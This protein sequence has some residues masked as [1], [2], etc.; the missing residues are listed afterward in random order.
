MSARLADGYVSADGHVVEPANLWTTRMDRRF[1]D[2]A[3]HIETR[4][5]VDFYVIDGLDPVAVGLDGA[6]LESK[7][8]GKVESPVARH[9]DT[10]PGAWDP[11]ERLKDQALDNL[12][13]EVI[14]PGQWSLMFY[15]IADAEYQRAAVRVYNDWL[16]EFCAYAPHR[17]LGAAILPMQGPLEWAAE[18]AERAA[19]IGLKAVMIPAA[20]P[21][22]PYI[23]PD[24][25][26]L[27]ARLE[28]IGLPVVAHSGTA[29]DIGASTH[30]KARRIGPGMAFMDEKAFQ[31]MNA[32]TELIW[33][34]A[35]QRYPR[36]KFIISEGGIGWIACL[37]RL[38]DHWWEDHH[39]WMQPQLNEPPSTYF[40]RQFWA[41]FEDDRAGI[42]TRELI[43]VERLMWGADYPHTEG[44]FPKSRQQI[45]KDFTGVP[46]D[47]VYQMVVGNA[48]QLFGIPL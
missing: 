36:L 23:H 21:A 18:E 41:T 25:E 40:K 5:S 8:A 16:S 11:Q 46:D 30:E 26:P 47:E 17:L 44:T 42:L 45:A 24:Y 32:L 6:A 15:R 19:K 37:L 1:R 38:M 10:R 34:G 14:Y 29:A 22:R 33:S 13:A 43:G 39:H 9:A 4:K 27:W 7:I 35:P 20:V 3:P 12:R 31:P 2:R 48:A 28:E